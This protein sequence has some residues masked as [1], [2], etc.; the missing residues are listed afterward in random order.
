MYYLD[1][2]VVQLIQL[3][4]LVMNSGG[5]ATSDV[6]NQYNLSLIAVTFLSENIS[7]HYFDL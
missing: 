7:D 1:I 6:G 2:L 4:N 3:I 5:S